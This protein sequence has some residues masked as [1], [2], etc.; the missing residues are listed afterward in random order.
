MKRTVIN[1]LT[2]SLLAVL[3][4]NPALAT[5]EAE[6]EHKQKL[7][8]LG[9]TVPEAVPDLQQNESIIIRATSKPY[10]GFQGIKVTPK[11]KQ[12]SDGPD[13]AAQEL[14]DNWDELSIKDAGK[15]QEKLNALIRDM[16]YQELKD[17]Y[18]AHPENFIIENALYQSWLL[19]QRSGENGF[20]V[21]RSSAT[22]TEPNDD[23]SSANAVSTDTVLSLIHI[24]EPTRPY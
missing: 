16:S 8:S 24:S 4:I 11:P 22:E 21:S 6:Q 5:D 9:L 19:T 14:L 7:E 17:L 10:T 2:L 20:R 23:M 1:T 3:T 12:Y 15:A 13:G 18:E